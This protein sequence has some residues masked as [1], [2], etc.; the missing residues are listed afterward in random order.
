MKPEP[1]GP[2]AALD[3]RTYPDL[4]PDAGDPLAGLGRTAAAQGVTLAPTRPWGRW[5]A[6]QDPLSVAVESDRGV[7]VVEFERHRHAVSVRFTRPWIGNAAT[8]DAPTLHDTVALL[9]AWQRQVPLDEM[10]R[11][12]P[13][14]AIEPFA[15]ALEQGRALSYRWQEVRSLP[16]DTIDKDLVEAAYA[17]PSLRALYPIVS[18]AALAFSD[19]PL[20]PHSARF[21]RATRDGEHGWLVGR[22]DEY[23]SAHTPAAGPDE[24]VDAL[25]RLLPE[26]GGEAR[27]SADGD[28]TDTNRTP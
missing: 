8:A 21:P 12:W 22:Q 20:P 5:D 25:V 27:G 9:D 13:Y 16:A 17:S 28:G 18:H 6:S 7:C 19:T 4:A 24:A 1:G 2:N 10:G 15:L 11:R 23:A 3:P 14:L 26:T